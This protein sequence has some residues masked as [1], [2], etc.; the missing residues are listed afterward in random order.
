MTVIVK[1][2]SG[3]NIFFPNFHLINLFIVDIIHLRNFISLNYF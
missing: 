3:T 1:E 2:I